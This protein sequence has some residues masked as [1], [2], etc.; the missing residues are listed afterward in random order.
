M[1]ERKKRERRGRTRK[2]KVVTSRVLGESFF[3]STV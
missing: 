1:G 2:G 3:V